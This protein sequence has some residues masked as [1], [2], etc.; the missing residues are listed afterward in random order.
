MIRLQNLCVV[1]LLVLFLS[2]ATVRAQ[3]MSGTVK[4]VYPAQRQLV[5][6]D[7]NGTPNVFGMDEDAQVYVDDMPAV[8]EDLQKGDRVAVI[9]RVEEDQL[10]AIEI[11]CRK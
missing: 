6:A 2:A 5:V 7:Q 11:R 8:L 10:L 1:A 4:D 9:Y 3:Q